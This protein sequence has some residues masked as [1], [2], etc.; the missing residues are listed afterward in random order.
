MRVK[1][2]EQDSQKNLHGNTDMFVYYNK[3]E[4]SIIFAFDIETFGCI[5]VI[6]RRLCER[7]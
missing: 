5:F 3:L 4:S 1:R 7:S 2:E 6:L